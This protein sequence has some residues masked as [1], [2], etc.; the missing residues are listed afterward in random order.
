MLDLEGFT[1]QNMMT[2]HKEA[3]LKN[4]VYL[5]QKPTYQ[6]FNFNGKKYCV[7]KATFYFVHNT[8]KNSF[9]V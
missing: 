6:K 7:K 4:R 5:S 2:I 9:K 8:L 3:M 1:Y